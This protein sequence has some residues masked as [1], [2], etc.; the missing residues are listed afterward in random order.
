MSYYIA[1]DRFG[2]YDLA[3]YGVKGMKWGKHYK[4]KSKEKTTTSQNAPKVSSEYEAELASNSQKNQYPNNRNS[5]QSIPSD[6]P[7]GSK[8][9][10]KNSSSNN[11]KSSPEYDAELSA[12]SQKNQMPKSQ[13]AGLGKALKNQS[14]KADVGT[15]A[16]P[17]DPKRGNAGIT[18]YQ[19]K[20]DVGKK[21]VTTVLQNLAKKILGAGKL[22]KSVAGASPNKK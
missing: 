16:T 19:A 22:K 14:N 4:R 15:A 9:S 2:N 6:Q 8:Y 1:S 21:L 3:H 13:N 5:A 10:G 20:A 17:R 11:Q 7:S 18:S 12:N